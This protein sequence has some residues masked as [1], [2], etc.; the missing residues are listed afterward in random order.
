MKYQALKL[1]TE[2]L[3]KFIGIF[4]PNNLR[5]HMGYFCENSKY[6]YLEKKGILISYQSLSVLSPFM[7]LVNVSPR[8]SEL[9][10]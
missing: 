10:S 1:N 3:E 8:P 5:S 6:F 2:A 7:F 4:L 9:C